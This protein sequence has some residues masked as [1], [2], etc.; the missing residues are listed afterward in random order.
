M[1]KQSI[2]N[3]FVTLSGTNSYSGETHVETGKLKLTE[4]ARIPDASTV[5]IDTGPIDHGRQ[6]VGRRP[7]G[8]IQ[9]GR[10]LLARQVGRRV[11]TAV[12]EQL[13]EAIG[14]PIEIISGIEEARL[15]YSGV[16]NSVGQLAASVGG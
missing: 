6:D 9:L 8:Q 7:F 15:I 4:S 5:R 11:R 10:R 2:G 3:N 1:V 14:Y 12:T 13:E 16:A